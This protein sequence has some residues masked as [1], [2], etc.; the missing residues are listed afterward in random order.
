MAVTLYRLYTDKTSFNNLPSEG[1]GK[2]SFL[3]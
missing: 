1:T 3:C 2:E